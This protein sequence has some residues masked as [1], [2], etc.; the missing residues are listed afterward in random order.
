MKEKV[1]TFVPELARVLRISQYQWQQIDT[2][3]SMIYI[4]ISVLIMFARSDF[5]NVSLMHDTHT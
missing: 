4:A 3:E 1:D 5:L 2:V